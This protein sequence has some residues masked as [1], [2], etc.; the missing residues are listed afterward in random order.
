G[1]PREHVEL[2]CYTNALEAFGQS[3]QMKEEDWESASGIDQTQ[4]FH[5]NSVLRGGQKAKVDD[6]I[7]K[8]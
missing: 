8:N 6:K 3:G 1:I 7:I 5:G 2:V 4:L